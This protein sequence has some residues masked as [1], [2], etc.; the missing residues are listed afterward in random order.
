M[1]E[2]AAGAMRDALGMARTP[3]DV[4]VRFVQL[5]TSEQVSLVRRAIAELDEGGPKG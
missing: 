2:H 3:E 5:L 1:A 4:L